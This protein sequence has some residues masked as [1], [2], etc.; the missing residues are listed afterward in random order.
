MESSTSTIVKPEGGGFRGL[1][2]TKDGTS[3]VQN[4]M[5]PRQR[6]RGSSAA[7]FVRLSALAL[8]VSW[9]G[10]LFFVW[11]TPSRRASAEPVPPALEFP[12]R[13]AA[14]RARE[15]ARIAAAASAEQRQSA[16]SAK[17]DTEAQPLDAV[18]PLAVHQ[19]R[20]G[21]TME[22]D[23]Q[24]GLLVPTFWEPPVGVDELAH[25]DAVN[26]E[27]TIFLMIASYRDWQCRDTAASALARAT[28]PRRVVVA[29]VQQNRPGDVGCA[30]P[31][32]PCSED[33]HQPL[34]KYSSQVRVY[35]MDA[36]D[37]TGPVYARH[38]GYRMY[39]GEAFALQ[40]DA[41]CVF[42]NGWD[43]GIIDQWK[44]TR[45]EMA[46]LSTYLTDLEGSVSP[47]GDSLRKTRPIMCNSDF[48]GSPGYLRHGA[49]PERVPAIRDVPMLQPYWA[50]GFSFARGHFVH[51]V[52][53][54]CCLPMVFMGEE[55]S[56]GVRAWTHGYDMYA[57]QASVLFHEYAQKSSRRRHVPKFWESKGARRANGQKSLRRLTS[58]IK[59]APPDMPDDWDRTKASLYGLG[60]DRPVDLFYKL[61]LVDVSRRSAVPLCQFVDSGDMHRM[62]HDAHLRAD[63]RGID[64][65]GAARQLDVMKVI[66]KRL[67]D[68][69]SNQLRR[70]VERGDK[71]LARNA[72]SEAQR[73]KLEKHHPELRELVDEARRLKGAQRS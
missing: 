38:V 60:T 4:T 45:N 51:R 50:A 29:A 31:P 42:V 20:D 9:T 36:N 70:A 59:M 73:T 10:L 27:P 52:R 12:L 16:P 1:D 5:R 39:R 14:R 48:E 40:V 7:Q 46:V 37:A 47:S 69:I 11:A 8:I 28:H 3:M 62:L 43:V 49:Q 21:F 13:D 56:I 18:A 64:Y 26:G 34:C 54:D 30:D 23:E 2:D 63:G 22:R 32:V 66:D 68:P 71:N 65:T 15:A 57:P 24:T 33:P 53:Y 35:A 44:R 72:L 61:A 67:Y 58:L 25:V 6:R 55:I 19:E 41:H 17:H